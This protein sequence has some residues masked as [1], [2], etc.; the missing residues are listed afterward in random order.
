MAQV[1]KAG[2]GSAA[3]RVSTREAPDWLI[4]AA[5]LFN[6]RAREILPELGRRKRVTNAK[7]QQLLGWTPRSNEQAI[8]ATGESLVRLGLLRHSAA[9]RATAVTQQ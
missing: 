4:R 7:A 8:L 1:L 6:P 2:L 9:D 3:E 5:A